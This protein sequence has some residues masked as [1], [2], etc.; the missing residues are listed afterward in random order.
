[1]RIIAEPGPLAS[2]VAFASKIARGRMVR[3]R[4]ILGCVRITAEKKAGPIQIQAH[5]GEAWS[6]ASCQQ[7]DIQ[8]PG[9]AVVSADLLGFAIGAVADAATLTLEVVGERLAVRGDNSVSHLWTY[10]VGDFPPPIDILKPSE[11]V[12][13]AVSLR[14][15]LSRVS[16]SM[17]DN[18]SKFA[19]AGMLLSRTE[20][21]LEF[22]ATSGQVLS[23][24]RM[25]LP[26][27]DKL[28]A[29]L[30]PS[31]VALALSILPDKEGA[32]LAT[33]IIGEAGA[34]LRFAD[35]EIRTLLVEGVFPDFDFLIP[36]DKAENVFLVDAEALAGAIANASHF[37]GEGTSRA[38]VFRCNGK[39][40]SVET[41][42]PERGEFK[43][44]LDAEVTGKVPDFGTKGEY[45][46]SAARA[47]GTPQVAIEVQASTKPI[48]V[49][50]GDDFISL[51]QPLSPSVWGGA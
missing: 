42:N 26:K 44:T 6:C 17:A 27:G 23:R 20:R 45:L 22:I 47:C 34:G 2:I 41:R 7:V 13:D 30:P 25:K 3:A 48:V 31:A 36:K 1:M 14:S 35:T 49:R 43:G 29:I 18:T 4:P 38:V 50:N 46:L 11:I 40:V 8:E 9:E 15:A 19:V 5:N 39:A 21:A 10:P 28:S 33:V 37:T 12:V 51:W 32:E 24:V 16:T